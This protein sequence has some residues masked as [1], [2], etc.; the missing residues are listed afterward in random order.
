MAETIVIILGAVFVL[1]LLAQ[2]VL[3]P[4]IVK[5]KQRFP[6]RPSF[7]ELGLETGTDFPRDVQGFFDESEGALRGVG[8]EPLC[9]LAQAEHMPNVSVF[10]KLFENGSNHDHALA[11]VVTGKTAEGIENVQERV[12]EFATGLSDDRVIDTNDRSEP[13]AFPGPPRKDVAKMPVLRGRVA[14]LYAVHRARVAALSGAAKPVVFSRPGGE[15]EALADS[16]ARDYAHCVDIG[17][18]AVDGHELAATWKGACLMTWGLCWPII[19]LRRS[20][21]RRRAQGAL[22][23]LGQ[24]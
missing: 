5:S 2:F 21:I 9:F 11:V 12:V 13:D 22:A 4:L 24:A 7:E 17:Y 23:L 1:P 3:G 8:F 16:M 19:S 20:A 18:Y 14:E 15:A 6:A 10:L